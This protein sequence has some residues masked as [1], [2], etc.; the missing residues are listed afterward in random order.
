MVIC[1][2]QSC[3]R[4]GKCF[5]QPFLI[6][7]TDSGVFTLGCGGEGWCWWRMVCDLVGIWAIGWD[8][9]G[10]ICGSRVKARIFETRNNEPRDVGLLFVVERSNSR[11]TEQMTGVEGWKTESWMMDGSRVDGRQVE[12][13]DVGYCRSQ[14]CPFWTCTL[15]LLNQ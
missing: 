12:T 3:A 4:A 11:V 5:C 7:Q 2:H 15:K 10:R 1:G 9:N 14:F 13:W 6:R 8:L